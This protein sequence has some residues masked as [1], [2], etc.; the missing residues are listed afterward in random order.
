MQ[1]F[2]SARYSEPNLLSTLLKAFTISSLVYGAGRLNSQS[3]CILF[4][5]NVMTVHIFK[6]AILHKKEAHVYNLL[7]R[8]VLCVLFKLNAAKHYVMCLGF[9]EDCAS[10][11]GLFLLFEQRYGNTKRNSQHII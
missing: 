1:Q 8:G 3:V 10:N 11:M 5:S 4:Q 2:L 6:L 9:E 7:C